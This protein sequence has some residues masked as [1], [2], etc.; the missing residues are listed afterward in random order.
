MSQQINLFNPIFLKQRKRLTAASMGAALG[1]LAL[2][3]LALAWQTRNNLE[4]LRHEASA[5]AAQ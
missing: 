1:A 5:A 3:L 2:A 4:G